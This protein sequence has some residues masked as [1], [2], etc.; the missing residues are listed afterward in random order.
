M[1]SL[2][3]LETKLICMPLTSTCLWLLNGL[4]IMQY[5]YSRGIIFQCDYC[6]KWHFTG[7]S[8]AVF[9]YFLCESWYLYN[10][11]RCIWQNLHRWGISFS[12]YAIARHCEPHPVFRKKNICGYACSSPLITN[13][14]FLIFTFVLIISQ[15]QLI[16]FRVMV[17]C[18]FLFSALLLSVFALLSE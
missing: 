11:S 2:G 17:C 1:I 6:K 15:S 14:I 13:C 7:S 9:Y 5:F 8:V 12:L 10:S 4:Q 3:E 16:W 18:G